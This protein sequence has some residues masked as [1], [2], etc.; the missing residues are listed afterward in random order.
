M[1][2]VRSTGVLS[3]EVNRPGHKVEYSSPS[4]DEVMKAWSYNSIIRTS[5]RRDVY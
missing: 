1:K 2:P 4:G 5:K 3:Q